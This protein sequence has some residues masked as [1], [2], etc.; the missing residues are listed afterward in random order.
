MSVF[1]IA[2]CGSCWRI[3]PVTR[4]THYAKEMVRLAKDAGANAVKFQFTSDPRGM[5]VR[6]KVPVGSY[7]ILHWPAEWIK[8]F[9]EYAKTLG[10]EFLC[11]VFLPQDVPTVQ[12]YVTK[13]KI[14]SLEYLSE[15]MWKSMA[16]CPQPIIA[17]IGATTEEEA[18]SMSHWHGPKDK[19]LMCTAAYPAPPEAMNLGVLRTMFDGLSDH[20]GD[21]LTGAVAVG[22]GA[23]ILEV[24]FRLD[25]TKTDNPDY[26]HSLYPWAFR[27]YIANVRKAERL[28]GDGYKKIELCESPLLKHRV[29]G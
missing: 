15:T 14:A 2:E 13:L 11:T 22:V 23:K 24:H 20:S 5:E 9:S 3:G 29:T 16:R 19:V 4:H 12:P 8:E 7:E 21:L 6:R 18:M 27:Q 28:L 26:P 17:S 25:G 10:M 1:I